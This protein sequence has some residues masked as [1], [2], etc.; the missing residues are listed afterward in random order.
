MG[1]IRDWKRKRVL[2]K[3]A[4]DPALWR[5]ATARL[6]FLAGLDESQVARLKDMAV[7]FLAEKELTPL[8]GVALS[9]R[10]RLS[11]AIQA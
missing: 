6:P 10:D 11:I 1:W 4:I 5:S 2:G 8:A 3:H 7:L 9:D